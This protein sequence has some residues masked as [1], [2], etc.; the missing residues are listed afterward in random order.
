MPTYTRLKGIQNINDSTLCDQLESN[1]IEF[2]NWGLLCIGGFANAATG[3]VGVVG[4]DVSR[5]R[6]V[7]DP[8]Y[9]DGQVW[10]GFRQNWVWESGIEYPVQP[11]Q[12][13]GVYVNGMFYPSNSVGQY[14]HHVNYPWGRIVFDTALPLTSV[15]QAN[16]S[17]RLFTIQS[18]DQ[19]WFRQVM[20]ESFRVDNSD[21]L[22][23]GSGVWNVLAENRVQLPAI[24]VDVI[25]RRNIFGYELGGTSTIQ[26]DVLFHIFTED[27]SNRKLLMDIISYQK[28]KTIPLFDKNAM[29][30][31]NRFPL[32]YNGA[33]APGALTY[34]ALVQPIGQGG[35]YWNHGTTFLNMGMQETISMP[36]LYQ[37]V[38]RATMEIN[39]LLL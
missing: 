15:V 5:L 36:P 21:F 27:P 12:V 35:F 30:A 17:Y 39:M 14:A 38:V 22:Q 23:Y 9:T 20:F 28:D 34:P 18:S 10:E 32:D 13:S 8:G 3:V 37:A 33:I 26:Q 16:Y 4:G 31:Q 19:Q 1:L 24:I 11:V 29:A 25:P 7:I 2:F 6:P